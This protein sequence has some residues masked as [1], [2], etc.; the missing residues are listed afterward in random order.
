VTFTPKVKAARYATDA[1]RKRAY[2]RRKLKERQA[3]PK[4]AAPL[5]IGVCEWCGAK[6]WTSPN[7]G[8]VYC[9]QS[10]RQAAYS[11]RRDAAIRIIAKLDACTLTA[12]EGQIKALGLKVIAEYLQGRGY[13]YSTSARRWIDKPRGKVIQFERAG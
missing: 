9:S 7:N 11:A 8:R 4:E 2:A 6:F 13:V 3:A 5:E 12:A 10:H 1:C